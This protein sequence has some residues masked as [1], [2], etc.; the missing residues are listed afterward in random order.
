MR[1]QRMTVVRTLVIALALALTVPWGMSPAAVAAAG[2]VGGAVRTDGGDPA[3]YARVLFY[4]EGF[5]STDDPAEYLYETGA[6]AQGRWQ[7]EVSDAGIPPGRYLVRAVDD[8]LARTAWYPGAATPESARVVSAVTDS[9]QS[10]IDVTIPG[11]PRLSGAVTNAAGNPV[12]GATVSL[13]PVGATPDLDS[14]VNV[15]LTGADGRWAMDIEYVPPGSYLLRA[16][17]GDY[18]AQW[19]DAAPDAAR[20]TPISVAGTS[21]TGLDFRLGELGRLGGV[22]SANGGRF[23]G[24]VVTALPLFDPGPEYA[25]E[26][27]IGTGEG[28]RYVLSGLPAGDYLVSAETGEWGG[29]PM[30]WY[31]SAP[32]AQAAKPVSVTPGQLT[33]AIDVA[34]DFQPNF[35]GK[36]RKKPKGLKV[37]NAVRSRPM[38]P[39]REYVGQRKCIHHPQKGAVALARLIRQ[40]YGPITTGLNRACLK[41]QS[42]HYDGRAIDWMVNSRNRAQAR[43]GDDFVEWLTM[44]RGPHIAA[45]ARRL[46][47]MYLIW[48]D[49]VWKIY[50]AELGWQ[51]YRECL[52]PAF[53]SPANDNDCHRNHVHISLTWDGALKR[54][55]WWR[56]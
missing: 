47:I 11:A 33:G 30:R 54:S 43:K 19:F 40:R 27:T 31:T 28:G 56:G 16:G 46:G 21:R 14:P 51:P 13:F 18:Q 7:A 34:L 8:S 48:R 39:V 50:Q 38:D 37:P 9:T 42:E 10:Q 12:V 2:S 1:H 29:L 17:H 20:A 41:D 22:I 53:R 45:M 26:F 35:P 52:T 23:A 36:P 55:S 4:P 3:A 5:T 49:R 32:T 24:L 6:D 15:V 25:Q 44:S